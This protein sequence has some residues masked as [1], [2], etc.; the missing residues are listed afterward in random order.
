MLKTSSSVG[1]NAPSR[2]HDTALPHAGKRNIFGV[3]VLVLQREAA[4]ERID[5]AVR[6]MV[7][8][9]V[10][11]LNANGANLAAGDRNY[12]HA[13]SHFDVL[14]DGIGVDTAS[15]VLYG[16]T[17][18]ANLNGTDFLP[19]LLNKLD[20][21]LKIGLFG[22]A[23]GVASRAM[24]EL[25]RFAPQHFYRTLG[26]GYGGE[27][28]ETE[29]LVKLARQPVDILLVALGN[30]RQEMWIAEHVTIAHATVPIGVGAFFDFMAGEVPRAPQ[31]VIDMRAEWLFRLV[32]EPGRL[33]RRY[34]LGNPVFLARV[35][36]QKMFGRA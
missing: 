15:R 14:A 29:V 21:P 10:A 6:E 8:T 18:P 20:G 11:F 27:A 25:A 30:P 35:L 23:P 1:R 28:A 3:D 31:W 36:A 17:F 32:Q 34:I 24:N 7:H 13:L 16:S 33:W 2:R 19:V 26:D 12:L 4:I 5:F 9:P 22:A